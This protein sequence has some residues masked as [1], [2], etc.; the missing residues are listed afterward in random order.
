MRQQVENADKDLLREIVKRVVEMLMGAEADIICSAPYR[1]SSKD[2]VD[3]LND[4]W[5][6]R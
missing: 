6:R 4:Y 2:R 3:H 5:D 1:Q